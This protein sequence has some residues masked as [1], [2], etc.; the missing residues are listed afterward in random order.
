MKKKLVYLLL[1]SAVLCAC[2][3]APKDITLIDEVPEATE[4]ADATESTDVTESS[5]FD[6][7]A[8]MQGLADGSSVPAFAEYIVTAD[9]KGEEH[10]GDNVKTDTLNYTFVVNRG[11]EWLSYVVVD[12]DGYGDS[13]WVRLEDEQEVHYDTD[14]DRGV[15]TSPGD[16][17]K[18]ETDIIFGNLWATDISKYDDINYNGMGKPIEVHLTPENAK[19]F[20]GLICNALSFLNEEEGFTVELLVPPTYRYYFT[21]G[22]SFPDRIEAT[23]SFKAINNE[24]DEQF[25]EYY[26]SVD[27]EIVYAR[28]EDED[29]LEVPDAVL[30]PEFMPGYDWLTDCG[31]DDSGVASPD[32]YENEGD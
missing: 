28:L 26:Y 3:T 20:D 23:Y 11:T 9:I 14:Y 17:H 10:T 1:C 30:S 25:D 7:E 5:D 4:S 21:E 19:E 2:S 24:E 31:W 8:F 22:E 27:L 6:A 15:I 29:I 13:Y 32:E 12:Q 18:F 16:A